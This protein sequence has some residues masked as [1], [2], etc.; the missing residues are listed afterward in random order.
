MRLHLEGRTGEGKALLR[1]LLSAVFCFALM[2]QAET[3][4]PLTLSSIRQKYD[5]GDF[6]AAAG[7]LLRLRDEQPAVYSSLPFALMRARALQRAGDSTVAQ[8]AYRQAAQ[9][10]VLQRYALLP[11]ARLAADQKD[12]SVAVQSYQ[13]YLALRN[14]PEFPGVSRE[15]LDYCLRINRPDLMRQ[16]AQLVR[17]QYAFRRLAD[18]YIAKS[19]ALESDASVAIS[20]YLDLI[21]KEVKDDVTSLAL[22]ELD[23]MQ[24]SQLGDA[25]KLVRG[26]LAYRVWNFEL[27][28]KYLQPAA[29]KN[30]DNAYYY[31]RALAFLG[32]AAG[33]RKMYQSAIGMWPDDPMARLC[34]YQYANLCLRQGDNQRAAELFASLRPRATGEILENATFNLVQALRAQSKLNEAIQVIGPYCASRKKSQRERALFLR[35]RVYFQGKRYKEALTDINL[36]LTLKSSINRK[37]ILFWKGMILEK[38]D[39]HQDA[40]A[41]FQSLT[42]GDD[43]FS[44]LVSDRISADGKVPAQLRPPDGLRL[45]RLPDADQEASILDR[46]AAGDLLTP[47]LYL[48]LY[49]EAART[50]PSITTESWRILGVDIANRS[51]KLLTIAYL[52][53]L[54]GNYPVATYYS[55]ILL[56]TVPP[57]TSLLALPT[58][59]LRALFPVPYQNVVRKFSE[60]RKIDPYLVL[61]IM[62]Q[63]S[64]FKEFARSQAFARGLMQ[65][66]PSTA[67]QVAADLGM[68]QFSLDQLYKPETN[69]NLG[70]RY[71]Q[72]MIGKFGPR[73]EV[74]AASYNSGESNVRRWLSLVSSDDVVEFYSNI[75]LPETKS[76]VNLVKT[77]YEIYKRVYGK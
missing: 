17:S 23:A 44:L 24:G 51:E 76:Y 4:E 42:S 7:L 61:S 62:K 67:M 2:V 13:R 73:V 26:K 9:D 71:V 64:K 47:L 30:M 45:C 52:A 12:T 15:A 36:L 10:A 46:A 38:L 1:S 5:S 22:T 39:M 16:T 70:T 29:L 18:F 14:A 55:E 54:G 20:L 53:G 32:D 59:V 49:E 35:A 57:G 33:A 40:V 77:N 72:D 28:R 6:R 25:E 68:T 69:I 66:I 21:R 19:H 3:P 58:D 50:L 31:A 8:E 41:V 43:F 34:T 63:E 60:E 27:T 65:L 56:K 75:D 37:E 74:I 11:L 48:H